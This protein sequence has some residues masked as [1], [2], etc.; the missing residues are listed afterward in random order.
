MPGITPGI[1][2]QVRGEDSAPPKTVR[3]WLIVF[4]A[5]LALGLIL[6]EIPSSAETE[7]RRAPDFPQLFSDVARYLKHY[8]LDLERI[9]PKPLLGKA[10]LDLENAA[11]EIYV[12]D[13]DPAKSIVAVHAGGKT[14][15]FD[16]SK[17]EDLDDSVHVLEAIF[18]FLSRS[19]TGE[20]PLNEVRY[21]AMNGFLTGIDPHTLVFSPEDFKD[22]S[23]HIEGEICGV[24]MYVGARDGK[25]TVLEVLKGTP[26]FQAGFK[27]NDIL[28][29]IGDESTINMTV[30]EAVDRI[31]GVCGTDVVLTVKRP[32]AADPDMLETLPIKVERDRVVIKSVESA[33]I[34]DWTKDETLPWS[35]GI[36]YVQVINFDKNTTPSLREHLHSLETQNGKPLAGL[37][38]DLRNN[39]GGL[40]TQAVEMSDLFLRSGEI[41][42]TA[43]NREPLYVQEAKAN[44][45]EPAYPIIVLSNEAS[46]SGAEIVIGALQKNNRAIVLG[47]RTF[48]KGSVQQLHHLRYDAELK[49]TVSEYLLPG[50]VSI[51]E[52]GVVPNI[53][54]FPVIDDGDM[55]LFPNERSV[56]ER[57]YA[58]HLVSRYAKKETPA[59]TCHYLVTPEEGDPYNDRFM[60]GELEPMKDALVKVALEVFQLAGKPFDP[61]SILVEREKEIEGIKQR[62]LDGIVAR[63]K[64]KGVDWSSGD[65]SVP[66]SIEPD[67][68][69]LTLSAEQV[70]EP[71]KEADDPVP[72][73]KLRIVAKLENTGKRTFYRLKGLSSSDYFL[74]KDREFLFGRLGPG[75]SAEREVK[76][77]LPY[78][79]YTRNDLFTVEVSAT[80]ELPVSESRPSDPVLVSAGVA[81]EARDRGRPSFA[82]SAVLLDPA[83]EKPITD[84]APGSEAL[85]RMTVRNNGT[86]PVYKG[87]TIL[88]N[89][90]G[91]EIF[92]QRGRIEITS[93]EPGKE[94]VS[95]FRFDVR[96]GEPRTSYDFEV[97]AADSYSNASIVQKIKIPRRGSAGEK[98]FPNGVEFAPPTI[99]ASLVDPDSK[100]SVLQTS[101]G[102]LEL[103]ARVESGGQPVKTWVINTYLGDDIERS[104]DKIYFTSSEGKDPIDIETSVPLKKGINVFTVVSNDVHGL[105]TRQSLVVR[106][107]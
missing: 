2:S 42:I 88:R 36:G 13:V 26:A 97:A 102:T 92:L 11:D 52:N 48:G 105:Q 1:A 93:L 80:G 79:P 45:D 18:S 15:T 91:R 4:V 28:D 7:K 46:A 99:V 37:I 33:L 103:K 90:T 6:G 56:S 84:L 98:P 44:G 60:S 71:S 17:V 70:E 20:T 19:Y 16:L 82:Y 94:T 96:E 64:D 54:A 8:Y 27:K 53:L 58:G 81:V 43:S 73:T 40:L 101:R 100:E 89:E 12:E 57:N 83:T 32:S 65:G 30:R 25:L 69:K 39:S 86:A 76:V 87:I 31:R 106:R 63:L 51:Q 21:A 5:A 107:D 29:K 67:E 9:N 24:G 104:D 55:D 41:V 35:G 22:F 61:A 85:F 3:G 74:Y 62:L 23:T 95:E 47:T 10:L 68:L 50:K 38:L 77:R 78:F 49:I 75:E 34:K 59:F 14:E 66:S 72:V